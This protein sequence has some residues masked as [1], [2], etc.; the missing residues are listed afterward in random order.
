MKSEL[1][2][3]CQVIFCAVLC[4]N[5]RTVGLSIREHQKLAFT[6]MKSRGNNKSSTPE[7]LHFA[8]IYFLILIQ[9]IPNNGYA[10]NLFTSGG[11]DKI[12]VYKSQISA[13]QSCLVSSEFSIWEISKRR[14]SLGGG[15]ELA[16][17]HSEDLG[18]SRGSKVGNG[19]LIQCKAE[20][21]G[22]AQ[23]L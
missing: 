5:W 9:G 22:I 21:G 19:N 8:Y 14:Y 4:Y 12:H 2:I 10:E 20:W 3:L 15:Q 7:C 6:R 16:N 23:C 1:H 13:L 17:L 18:Y 11:T